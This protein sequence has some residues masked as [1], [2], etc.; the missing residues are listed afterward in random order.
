[1]LDL[2][3]EEA[4]REWVNLGQA[5]LLAG[6]QGGVLSSFTTSELFVV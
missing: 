2:L 3:E 6:R 4:T 1:M 5:R